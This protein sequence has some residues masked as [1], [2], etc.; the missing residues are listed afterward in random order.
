MRDGDPQSG[1][2]RRTRLFVMTLGWGRKPQLRRKAYLRRHQRLW[3]WDK[4]AAVL[5]SFVRL[6]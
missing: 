1:K 2:Y 4:S 6:V 5:G 3:L